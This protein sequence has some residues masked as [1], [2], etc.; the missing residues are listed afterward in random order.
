M[1]HMAMY[2]RGGGACSTVW[3]VILTQQLDEM[4][5]WRKAVASWFVHCVP[6]ML[7]YMSL[8]SWT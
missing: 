7:S 8:R 4:A 5:G 2:T 1:L 3:H 6:W